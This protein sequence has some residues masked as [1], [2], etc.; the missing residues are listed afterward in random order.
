MTGMV[1]LGIPPDPALLQALGKLAIAHGNLEMVQIMCLKTLNGLAPDEAFEQFRRTPAGVIRE[2][3][4]KVVVER[5]GRQS[6][7]EVN[8]LKELLLDARCASR[9]RN[10][11]L[12]RF[13]ACR[14]SAEWVTSPDESLWE[15]LPA[16]AAIEDLTAFIQTTTA[17]LNKQRFTGGLIFA[18]AMSASGSEHA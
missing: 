10:T 8:K 6:P 15:P 16:V 5:A 3:I 17:R 18:L 4:E 7:K 11:Y 9:R 12:H 14:A 13:W 2:N 1:Q